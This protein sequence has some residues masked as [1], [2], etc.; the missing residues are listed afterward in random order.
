MPLTE[1]EQKKLSQVLRNIDDVAQDLSAF[2]HLTLIRRV[3]QELK[4]AT[5][6]LRQLAGEKS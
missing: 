3:R 2:E 4:Q 5:R 1:Q 6:D